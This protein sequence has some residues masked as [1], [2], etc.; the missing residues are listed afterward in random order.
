MYVKELGGAQ[1]HGESIYCKPRSP[2]TECDL[3]VG[4]S[5]PVGLIGSQLRAPRYLGRPDAS[6]YLS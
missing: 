5:D 1:A 6:V 4:S 2:P 3:C